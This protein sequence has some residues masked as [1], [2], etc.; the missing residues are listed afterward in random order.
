MACAILAVASLG[1]LA[2]LQCVLVQSR[3]APARTGCGAKERPMTATS[4]PG[5]A[6]LSS[7]LLIS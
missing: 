2:I 5:L 1:V 7:F 6:L 4:G 3:R